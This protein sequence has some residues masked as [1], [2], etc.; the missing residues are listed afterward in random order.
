MHKIDALP[1]I[2]KCVQ[3]LQPAEEGLVQSVDGD[4]MLSGI[5]HN[6]QL[7]DLQMCLPYAHSLTH[8][9][10]IHVLAALC[11]SLARTDGIQGTQLIT[12]VTEGCLYC[13]ITTSSIGLLDNNLLTH[14]L[15]LLA[16]FVH[17]LVHMHVTE[18]QQLASNN[19]DLT[20][21]CGIISRRFNQ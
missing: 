17:W 12:T 7:S 18:Y 15:S 3:L 8:P 21:D 1:L 16:N 2:V 5:A 10:K 4:C 20:Y 11:G 14:S 13:I 19:Y 6:H 9:E